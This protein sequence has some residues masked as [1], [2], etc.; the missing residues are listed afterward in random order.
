[1]SSLKSIVWFLSLAFVTLCFITL[2]FILFLGFSDNTQ[3][4]DVAVILGNQVHRN[5]QPS[6]RL[7]ARLNEGITLYHAGLFKHII[8][9]G[10]IEKNGWSEAVVMKNYLVTH[11]IPSTAIIEDSHGSDT[12]DTALNSNVI[13]QK[14]GYKS[15]LVISQYFHIARI[16]LAFK[17]CGISPVYHAHANYVE[18]RD[19][20]STPREVLA[21]YY[22]LLFHF[23]QGRDGT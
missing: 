17:K 18:L 15:A 9:S 6:T 12:W 16:L 22:Y 4:A 8:V 11:H 3:P 2:G 20:Y 14:K 21:I 5:G 1:M 23:D 13:M 10:G 19:L 7:A